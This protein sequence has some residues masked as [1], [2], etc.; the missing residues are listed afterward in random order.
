MERDTKRVPFY[1]FVKKI[2]PPD[3][4]EDALIEAAHNWGEF[5]DVAWRMYQR[6]K[7]KGKL[8]EA[9]TKSREENEQRSGH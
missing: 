1:N 9:S 8:G 4:T 6:L 7:R 5:M 3:T 2:M